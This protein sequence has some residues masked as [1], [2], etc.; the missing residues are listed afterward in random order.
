[1]KE[2]GK[3]LVRKKGMKKERNRRREKMN[4]AWLVVT[5]SGFIISGAGAR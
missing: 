4:P 3:S 2:V 5:S 1:V